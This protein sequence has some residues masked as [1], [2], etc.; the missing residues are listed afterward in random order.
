MGCSCPGHS[1][2][3]FGMKMTEV[4]KPISTIEGYRH[5]VSFFPPA[6]GDID[7][8][9]PGNPDFA[10]KVGDHESVRV[11]RRLL[12]P[13]VIPINTGCNHHAQRSEERQNA[14]TGKGNAVGQH[15]DDDERENELRDKSLRG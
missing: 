7:D 4:P 6:P 3:N 15:R 9:P 10:N 13:D 8:V 1:N 14:A 2:L 11:D 12:E 5:V